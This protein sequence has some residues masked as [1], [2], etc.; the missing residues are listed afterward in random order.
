MKPDA[1]VVGGGIVGAATAFH[2]SRH[3]LQ[4][5]VVDKAPGGA[6][7][8]SSGFVRVHHGNDAVTD[9]ARDGWSEFVH[10]NDVVGAPTTFRP[11]GG[12]HAVGPDGL[13]EAA[14]QVRRLRDDLGV[15][16]ELYRTSDLRALYPGMCWLDASAAVWEPAAGYAV[17]GRCAAQYLNGVVRR[18]GWVSTA[19]ATGI[20]TRG[21]RLTAI[22][23]SDGAIATAVAVMAVGAWA[24]GPPLGLARAV[25]PV[26]VRRIVW[27]R[28]F[29]PERNERLPVFVRDGPCELCFRADGPDHVIVSVGCDEWDLDPDRPPLAVRDSLLRAGRERLGDLFGTTFGQAGYE[30]ILGFDGYTPDAIPIVDGWPD[31]K[32]LYV[33][34]G[35]SGGGFKL[36]PAVGQALASWITSGRRPAVID[37]FGLRFS[38]PVPAR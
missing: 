20:L 28:L 21:G 7:A 38:S 8:V 34:T 19:T 31:V 22:E 36:A 18:G 9:L 1:V 16:C 32:G 30:V 26:R 14:T 5:L 25:A 17:P 6:T 10:W 23:T 2:L 37:A 15:P 4:V 35:F 33:A 11:V 29:M 24:S 12:L 3:G 27:Q 13:A